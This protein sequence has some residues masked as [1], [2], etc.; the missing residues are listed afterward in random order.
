MEALRRGSGE[1]KGRGMKGLMKTAAPELGR[2]EM[3]A[4]RCGDDP[5]TLM[6]EEDGSDHGSDQEASS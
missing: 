3:T 5:W 4:C 2:Q 6:M 1:E